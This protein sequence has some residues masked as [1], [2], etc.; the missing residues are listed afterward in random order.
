MTYHSDPSLANEDITTGTGATY[1]TGGNF[2]L[3]V[4]QARAVATVLS[5]TPVYGTG[6]VGLIGPVQPAGSTGQTIALGILGAGAAGTGELA[7]ASTAVKN[8]TFRVVYRAAA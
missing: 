5:V 4:S 2:Q 8:T 7:N 6:T 3:V 1:A